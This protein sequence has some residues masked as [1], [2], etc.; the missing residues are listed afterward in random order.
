MLNFS[1]I[2]PTYNSEHFIE[3]ILINLND[4]LVREKY[5][6]YEVVIVNDFSNDQTAVIIRTICEKLK[7]FKILD[8]KKNIGQHGA[9]Y[10]GIYTAKNENIITLDDDI[11]INKVNIKSI[12]EYLNEY[13]LILTNSSKKKNN[14]IFSKIFNFFFNSIYNISQ[15]R[16]I[17][18]FRIFKKKI[19]E[20]FNLSIINKIYLSQILLENCHKKKIINVDIFDENKISRYDFFKNFRL[21]KNFFFQNSAIFISMLVFILKIQ[22]IVFLIFILFILYKNIFYKTLEGWTSLML[23]ISISSIINILC[24]IFL[25]KK[26]DFQ[27]SSSESIDDYIEKN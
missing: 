2:V 8:L 5:E 27:T 7:N 12:L 16:R 17:T 4:K 3:K 6:N 11:E 18:T 19:L 25:F 26:L 24:F 10:L 9:T 21:F 15:D 1:I 20:P 13:D 14:S 23:I 22:L